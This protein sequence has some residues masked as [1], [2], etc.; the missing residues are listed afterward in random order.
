MCPVCGDL[1]GDQG[2]L[3]EVGLVRIATLRRAQV[4]SRLGRLLPHQAIVLSNERDDLV[5]LCRLD[6]PAPRG[7]LVERG[8]RR[9]RERHAV[10]T[11]RQRHGQHA[12]RAE[13]VADVH[14]GRTARL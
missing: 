12:T 1:L 7:I 5:G 4:L 6:E 2:M 10:A 13:F 14:C 3:G 9:A 11:A 8:I